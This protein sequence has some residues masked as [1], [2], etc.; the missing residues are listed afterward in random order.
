MTWGRGRGDNIAGGRALESGK[1]RGAW[2]SRPGSSS[3]PR[4]VGWGSN[5]P[6]EGGV[7]R[8]ERAG[9]EGL[10]PAP[11]YPRRP[12]GRP[13]APRRAPPPLTPAPGATVPEAFPSRWSARLRPVSHHIVLEACGHRSR[14]P[15]R[16][17]PPVPTA[18]V[19]LP[20]PPPHE[21]RGAGARGR[22]EA[23]QGCRFSQPGRARG[24]K[25]PRQPGGEKGSARPRPR[26]K[27]LGSRALTLR[28]CSPTASSSLPRSLRTDREPEVTA[29]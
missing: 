27:G 15:A 12:G 21:A 18:S 29:T 6:E 25:A 20:A 28:S 17:R 24:A 4:G 7:G 5:R 1:A 10:A 13:C 19:R 16:P 23:R 2:G 8:R 14:L 9:E 26:G 22:A 3:R 11:S